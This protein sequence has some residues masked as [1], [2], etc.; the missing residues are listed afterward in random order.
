MVV[1]MTHGSIGLYKP[2]RVEVPDGGGMSG[3]QISVGTFSMGL[4]QRVWI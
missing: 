4:S 3:H 2:A 1:R